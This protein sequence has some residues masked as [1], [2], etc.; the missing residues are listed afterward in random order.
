MSSTSFWA[1]VK[2]AFSFRRNLKSI[3][4]RPN[5]HFAVLDGFRGFS[6]AWVYL[7]HVY[8][9][10][11][12]IIGMDTT[13]YLINNT[14][15]LFNWIWMGDL[16]V[17]VFFVVSGFLISGLLFREFDKTKTINLK[18]FYVRRILRLT[19]IYWLL[20]LAY[21]FIPGAEYK[22]KLW[23]NMFYLNNFLPM[24][25]SAMQW[26]WTLAV[27][28]Q[29]YVIFPLFL[30]AIFFTSQHKIKW[31]LGLLVLSSVIRFALIYFNKDLWTAS[32]DEIFET[33]KDSKF[34]IYIDALYVNLYSR[35]GSFI[36]GILA[37]YLYFYHREQVADIFKSKWGTP[38]AL[39]GA[40]AVLFFCFIPVYQDGVNY[41]R[42]YQIFHIVF[43][44]N[45]FA[46]GI[47]TLIIAGICR[48]EPVG[49][50]ISAVF[51]SRFWI[52]VA[53]LSYSTYIFHI[54]VVGFVVF[55]LKANLEYYGVDMATVNF[56]WLLLAVP[57]S[58]PICFVISCILY[59][60]IEK[61]F[62]NMRSGYRPILTGK[63]IE[64]KAVDTV[65]TGKN[66][67]VKPATEASSS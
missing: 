7:F 36:C 4:T 16:A 42:L 39:L 47:S 45:L 2:E 41:S 52:P 62:M 9:V 32:F 38:I 1:T 21:F 30:L 64:E 54:I 55:N 25:E 58:V 34:A 56:Y 19:P 49:K 22:E 33:T 57:L 14:P 48:S 61:P 13:R 15:V 5:D 24:E 29:F 66:Y 17:D 11:S 8:M 67:A 3:F 43:N 50:L 46:A 40:F 31:L 20:L 37:S 10:T 23:A 63:G 27:E 53:Q 26:T 59:V 6:M 12:F 60:F 51:G 44:R 28:E 18:T 65:S 35:F